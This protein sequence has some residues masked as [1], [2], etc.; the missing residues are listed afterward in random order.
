MMRSLF[1]AVSGLRAH[2]VRMDVIG[3]N[4]ANVNTVAY[5]RSRLG[6]KEMLAQTLKGASPPQGGM[7]GTNP[8][9]IGLGVAPGSVDVD[10][11]Q[12]STQSTGVATDLAIQGAGFFMV[13]GDPE[14]RDIQYTRNGS[15]TIDADGN[16]VMRDTG[17]KV[18]GWEVD[19]TTGTINTSRPT[20]PIRVEIGK[21]YP[22]KATTR[23]TYTGNL[24]A[25]A[26]VGTVRQVP[27]TVYDSL[28]SAHV[29]ILNFEKTA[30]NEWTYTVN[31]D[32]SDPLIQKFLQSFYPDFESLN[33]T[34]KA[35]VLDH[36]QKVFLEGYASVCGMG[37]PTRGVHVRFETKGAAN[38]SYSIEFVKPGAA[39]SPLD[40]TVSGSTITV[41]L[42]TDAGGNI[43]ST[44]NDV[45]TAL[46][47]DPDV[48]GAGINLFAELDPLANGSLLA[49]PEGPVAFKNGSDSQMTGKVIFNPD[50][51][52]DAD[53][54][55]LANGAIY[56][57][58][59]LP[60]MFWPEGADLL[61]IVP[62]VKSL[63]QFTGTF[64][65]IASK[66]NGN[67]SGTLQSI[68]IGQD[69]TITARFSNGFDMSLAV[70][71]T[72]TF[73]N[74][75]GLLRA[76]E[77]L[78]RQSPN[79]GEPDRNQ[80]GQGSHGTLL[81][82]SLEMSNVDLAQEFTD[83]ITTQRGF[84]ANTRVITTSDQMLEELANI[85]R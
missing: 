1:S 48:N 66:Q 45:V 46:N 64:T 76:G 42:A 63:T 79:S 84:Q 67:P 80:P 60:F 47:S 35:Q 50:G 40:V 5:K 55:R 43:I 71:A 75:G 82:G 13:S 6:F 74:P 58:L 33:D 53:A 20:G 16:L 9:Q 11:S 41:S 56:P 22:P 17:L 2:Q 23:I 3:N 30:D 18:H 72:A 39:N 24:D 49:Q 51:T 32:V 7:G 57:E 83:M 37:A 52:I 81:P 4:I 19:Q 68:S 62:D 8:I 14:A 21:S 59:T 77:G 10:F 34:Q 65:I 31:L 78:W 15:F 36:A 44:L 28:G 61:S 85:K 12:G 25:S 73:A 29:V 70:I 26:P 27:M 38:N 69:G 54:T